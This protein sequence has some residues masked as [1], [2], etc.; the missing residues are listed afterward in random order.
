MKPVNGAQPK[1]RELMKSIMCVRD[2]SC[3]ASRRRL[4][5]FTIELQ[6]ESLRLLGVLA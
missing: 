3:R 1:S 4:E 5:L 2:T 6:E